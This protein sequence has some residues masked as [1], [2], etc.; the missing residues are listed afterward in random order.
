MNR[1]EFN[2]ATAITVGAGLMGKI[3]LAA[4]EEE[5]KT[6]VADW[7]EPTRLDEGQEPAY[8]REFWG[9]G[10]GYAHVPIHKVVG[11]GKNATERSNDLNKK[12][13]ATSVRLL[14]AAGVDRNF[15]VF[16]CD[17]RKGVF[18][19]RLVALMKATH[20]ANRRSYLIRGSSIEYIL[21]DKRADFDYGGGGVG[22]FQGGMSTHTVY[23]I[24]VIPYD[25]GELMD[26]YNKCGY[27][28]ALDDKYLA[29]GVNTASLVNPYREIGPFHRVEGR[30]VLDNRDV[31]LGSY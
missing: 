6:L 3:A 9:G 11:E 20:Q 23:G 17:S 5:F 26:W 15:S 4:P 22:N 29:I 27:S 7:F 12:I 16:D 8:P 18:T 21:V 2:K 28:L 25:M 24:K 19:K 1:R 14:A 10:D 30:A 31:M 13:E